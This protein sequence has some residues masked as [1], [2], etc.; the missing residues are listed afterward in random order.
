MGCSTASRQTEHIGSSVQI[1]P[2]DQAHPK[3][4]RFDVY[5]NPF[6]HIELTAAEKA[7][8]MHKQLALTMRR[9]AEI[10]LRELG[11]CPNGVTGPDLVLGPEN[12]R[13]RL[14]FY[15]DCLPAR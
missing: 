1:T 12:D 10:K 4:V 2:D 9:N 15:V 14:F 7:L 6:P 3:R 11:Y 8:P 5:G 13:R